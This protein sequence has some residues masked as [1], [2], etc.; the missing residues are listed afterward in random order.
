[1][2]SCKNACGLGCRRSA[3]RA[4]GVP[5]TPASRGYWRSCKA[6]WE[7]FLDFALEVGAIGKTERQELEERSEQA[8]DRVGRT[9]SQVPACRRSSSPVCVAFCEPRWYGDMLTWQTEKAGHLKKVAAWGWQPD[10]SG[11]GCVA[12]GPCIGWVSGDDLFLEPAVSYQVARGMG[13]SESL[14]LSEQTLRR[15]LHDHGLLVSTDAGREMFTVRRTLDGCPRQVLHLKAAVLLAP[16]GN[17][18]VSG[19]QPHAGT[20]LTAGHCRVCRVCQVY[21]W[22]T[23]TAGLI[24]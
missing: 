21:R 13:G 18:R 5:F 8:L 12:Q 3:A 20:A 23:C 22:W 6:G 19:S 10:P 24:S 15:R 11:Q 2:K 16:A 1:M 4:A 14:P 7:I 9:P 17:Q